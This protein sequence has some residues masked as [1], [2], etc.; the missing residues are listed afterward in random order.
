MGFAAADEK[1]TLKAMVNL[2]DVFPTAGRVLA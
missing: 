1:T 2:R